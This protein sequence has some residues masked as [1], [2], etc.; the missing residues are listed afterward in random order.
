MEADELLKQA[1]RLAKKIKNEGFE[2]VDVRIAVLGS[3]SIQYFVMVLRLL[4]R[5]EGIYA[6]IY[7]GEYNGIMMDVMDSESQF[8]GFKP[9]IVIILP[10][11]RDIKEF[12]APLEEWDN[13]KSLLDAVVGNFKTYWNRISAISECQILQSNFVIPP[14]HVYGNI[15][16]RE[17]FTTTTFLEEI[18]RRL[19]ESAPPN[20]NIIDLDLL[21]QNIGKWNWFDETSYF[22]TKIGFRI[23]CIED[24][25]RTFIR[26]IIA[27]KGKTRKCL[28]LDLDNTLW[29]GIIGDDGWDGIQLDP[30][31]AVGEAFRDFQAYILQLKKRGVIL[32]VVSKNDE[33]I[34]K[35]PFERNPNMILHLDD[36]ASFQANWN[37]KVTNIRKVA[38]ELN[39]GIASLVFFDDNPAEREI[40]RSY[41]SDVMVI[42]V[43]KDPSLFKRALDQAAP[44][45]WLQLTKEDVLRNNSYIEN[46]LRSK[47]Q[48]QFTDYDE[49][50]KSL[51]MKGEVRVPEKKEL[52]RFTQLLNKSNQFNLRTRRYSESEIV[53]A[54]SAADRKYLCAILTDKFSEYGIISCVILQK[55]NETCFIESWVMS[56]RVLKRGVEDMVFR[57]VI[58]KAR[59]W[60]CTK[61]TGEYIPSNKNSMVKDFYNT[62]GFTL[63]GE[64]DGIRNY[65]YDVSIPF[66]K[67]IFIS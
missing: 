19:I 37:D 34:A 18:N 42:D 15:E 39:I 21:A 5:D 24:V 55:K 40:V 27:L 2:K 4:L 33:S 58:K 23:D 1:R 17:P 46:H 38:A 12:P 57:E 32:A 22:L 60:G 41:L 56:C 35:E 29:G 51:A 62:L 64:C 59:D 49:Y 53:D 3:A 6:D 31:N 45:D 8:Y 44:F 30:N 43:P 63:I 14:E 47:L 66:E 28:I 61:I 65:A 11:H 50:L 13:V 36:I 25:V 10:D 67:E 54:Y 26:Q 52:S 48:T 7:E 9:E 20:V 16:R